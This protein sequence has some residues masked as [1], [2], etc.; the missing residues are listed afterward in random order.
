MVNVVVVTG[1]TYIGKIVECV[2]TIYRDCDFLDCELVGVWCGFRRCN[3]VASKW[4]VR[5]SH[6]ADCREY[7]RTNHSVLD[8]HDLSLG[9][10]C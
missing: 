10:N 6:Y 9:G 1:E 3:F 2:N 4:K 8:I 5:H 7:D